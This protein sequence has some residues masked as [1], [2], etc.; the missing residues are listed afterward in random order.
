MKITTYSPK[1]AINKAYLKER[2]TREHID[3]F[4]ANFIH[5][6]NRLKVA[7]KESEEFYKNIISDFLKHTFYTPQ[8]EI[9]TRGVRI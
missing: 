5:L 8:Y 4:K 1:I 6:F 9:N 2:I 7:E 3:T